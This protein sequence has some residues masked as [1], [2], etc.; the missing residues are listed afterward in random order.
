MTDLHGIVPLDCFCFFSSDSLET[1]TKR[2]L[3]NMPYRSG[4]FSILLRFV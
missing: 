4:R 3:K 1:T 2:D